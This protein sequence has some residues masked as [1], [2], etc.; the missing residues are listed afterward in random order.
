MNKTRRMTARANFA[1]LKRAERG[2]FAVLYRTALIQESLLN[3]AND[4]ES[5]ERHKIVRLLQRV[6]PLTKH[7]ADAAEHFRFI[8]PEGRGDAESFIAVSGL[9]VDRIGFVLKDLEQK[10]LLSRVVLGA[11]DF[12]GQVR[13]AQQQFARLH[14]SWQ[15]VLAD[16]DAAATSFVPL[17]E[18]LDR[19]T[20]ENR[21]ALVDWG[22]PIGKEV[23]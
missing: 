1:S 8:L 18:L 3:F 6:A 11:P 15:R 5:A 10:G 21:H 20:P 23:W 14:A 4:D 17:D 19:V 16:Y 2:F 13:D 22:K 9:L 7:L 12:V